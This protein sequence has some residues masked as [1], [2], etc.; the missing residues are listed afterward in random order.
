MGSSLRRARKRRHAVATFA[1]RQ[2]KIKKICLW[3]FVLSESKMFMSKKIMCTTCRSNKKKRKKVIAIVQKRKRN[4][5]VMMVATMTTRRHPNV[6]AKVNPNVSRHPSCAKIQ[7]HPCIPYD[8]D[9]LIPKVPNYNF[10]VNR[11]IVL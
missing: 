10:C 6:V 5:V 1:D 11:L 9:K 2:Q 7:A 3:L 8:W 4:V